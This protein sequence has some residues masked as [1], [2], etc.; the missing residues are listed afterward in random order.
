MEAFLTQRITAI[1]GTYST[2]KWQKNYSTAVPIW[3]KSLF[4][5]SAM[6][7]CI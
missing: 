1:F 6:L 2:Q 7:F 4:M 3:S 5:V